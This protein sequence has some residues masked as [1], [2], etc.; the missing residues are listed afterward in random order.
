MEDKPKVLFVLEHHNP[1]YDPLRFSTAQTWVDDRGVDV[2]MW[3]MYDS[4]Q[5]VRKD[6]IEQTPE[7]KA[8]IDDLL[9]KG[10][11]IY[12]C[13]FCTRSCGLSAGDY[14][15]GVAVGNRNIYFSMVTERKVVTY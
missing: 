4:I 5:I 2:V 9:G 6:A 3:L 11:P 12:V 1:Q 15:P 8:M 13:G 10:V 14:Y 7:I